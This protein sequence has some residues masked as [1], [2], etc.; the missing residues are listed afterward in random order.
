ML[1]ENIVSVLN[2]ENSAVK[3]CSRKHLISFTI[4]FG[5]IIP[6]K[7]RKSVHEIKRPFLKQIGV[8]VEKSRHIYCSGIH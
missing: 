8:S 1:V 7:T 4:D 2:A 6:Q 5:W 3:C